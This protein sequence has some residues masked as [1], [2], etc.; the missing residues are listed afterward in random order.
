MR[1]VIPAFAAAEWDVPGPPVH[2]YVAPMFRIAPAAPRATA[3]RVNSVEHRNVPSRTIPVTARQA[4]ND[5]SSAGTG[6]LPAALLTSTS[7]GPTAPSTS[8]NAAATRSGSRTSTSTP[9]AR[10]PTASTAAIPAARWSGL[11]LAT[12]I[13]APSRA[14]STAIALP[15]PVPD[16]VIRTTAPA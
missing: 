2:E 15:R 3:R 8:S 9:T 11:R 1:L 13:V 5:M 4:L 6:K 16:P 14:N 10:L 12:A 7:T